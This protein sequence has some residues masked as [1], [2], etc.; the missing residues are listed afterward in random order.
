MGCGHY[1]EIAH[2]DGLA[3]RS[4]TRSRQ[5]IVHE[6][7]EGVGIDGIRPGIIGEIGVNGEERGTRRLLG[8]MTTTE[9][10]V[11]RA[12]ARAARRRARR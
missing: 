8:E 7:T 11:L 3:E 2:A 6:L 5:A 12:G 9:R 10:R 1:C 4:E